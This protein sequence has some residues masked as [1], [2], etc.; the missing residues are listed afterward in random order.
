[1]KT[2]WNYTELAEAYLKRPDYCPEAIQKLLKMAGVKAGSTACDIGA[3]VAHL[4]LHLAKAGL[5][6]TA[7]E[8]NDGMRK[9]GIERTKAMKNVTWFEGAAEK[10][11]CKDNEFD[12][13]T[14]GSSFNVTDRPAAMRETIRI[15][16]PSGWFACMWNHRDLKDPVQAK[17]EAFIASEISAYDYGARR[18]DQEEIINGSGLFHDVTKLEGKVMHVQTVA[19]CVRAWESHATLQRQAGKKFPQITKG[20]ESL[21]KGMKLD[22]VKVPYTTRIW[23]AQAR[24]KAKQN[25]KKAA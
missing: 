7:V 12:L 6:V 25:P 14:F 8:P 15:L 18:E 9:L 2:E 4:T 5:T 22:T 17:I 16:K 19:D 1:M 24:A 3:G 20:I 11:G 10:T 13:V 23:V 21:L